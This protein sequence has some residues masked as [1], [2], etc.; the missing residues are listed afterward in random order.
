V[1]NRSG[2]ESLKSGTVSGGAF[3]N[4]AQVDLNLLVALNDLLTERNV[5]HAG[6][7]LGLTQPAMSGQ[8]ARLRDLFKD[9]LL[10]RVGRQLELTAVA[11][12]LVEPVRR[13]LGQI[14]DAID[15]RRAFD[16][17]AEV[18][19]FTIAASDYATLL[20]FEPTSARLEG[21]APGVTCA[22]TTVGEDSLERL[23]AG[24]VDFVIEPAEMKPRQPGRLLFKDRWVCAL[25]AGNRDVGEC[26]TR[27]NFLSLP[28]LGYRLNQR[29]GL[30]STAESYLAE[31][32]IRRRIV[33]TTES[34]LL[35][36]FLLHGSRLIALI[37]WRI[38][39]RF[40]KAAELRVFPPPFRIPD[41]HD[42]LFWCARNTSTPAHAW[43]RSLLIEVASRL[44]SSPV[45]PG[46]NHRAND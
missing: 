14:E 43:F 5:T 3:T 15:R 12:E 16:P 25:W 30:A 34:F 46:T 44:P 10:V 13:V 21:E 42:S 1:R 7:R 29:R 17:K 40:R 26:L 32:G 35:L 23:D 45:G 2:S 33:A 28:H 39:E 20:L 4:L 11:Q 31:L 41:I 38:A 19:Q 22:F 9:E 37:Q 6:E 8:L 36:P 18:R 27:K 24:E